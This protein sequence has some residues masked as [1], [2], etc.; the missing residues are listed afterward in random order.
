MTREEE[1]KRNKKILFRF[2]KET[3]LYAEF[4]KYVKTQPEDWA[5]KRCIDSILGRLNFTNHLF[6]ERGL[7]LPAQITSIFRSYL[8]LSGL[9]KD[10]VLK[11]SVV[12]TDCVFY[13]NATNRIYIKGIKNR[14]NETENLLRH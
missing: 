8:V 7:R 4:K 13:D 2:L 10:L 5:E 14:K 6:C 3:G 1:V 12:K 9:S 11:Y